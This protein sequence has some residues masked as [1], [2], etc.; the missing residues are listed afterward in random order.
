M[1]IVRLFEKKSVSLQAETCAPT[2]KVRLHV[3]KTYIIITKKYEKRIKVSSSD[4]GSVGCFRLS[5]EARVEYAC[6]QHHR[7]ELF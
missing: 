1:K 2:C 5:T 6:Q 3:H 4:D 7:M